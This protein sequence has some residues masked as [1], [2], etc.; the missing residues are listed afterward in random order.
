MY[1]HVQGCRYATTHVTRSHLC[2]KCQQF[3]HGRIE[4]N[5]RE[6]IRQLTNSTKH[7]L[8]PF[9]LYCNV[10][11]CHCR[12]TH[13]TTGHVCQLCQKNHGE[14]EC[15]MNQKIVTCPICRKVSTILHNQQKI[16][17]ADNKCC[18]C[19]DKNVEVYLPKCGHLCLCNDCCDI[20]ANG[21]HAPLDDF[22]EPS[23]AM[24]E[25][26]MGQ[27]RGAIYIII[28]VEMG[29]SYYAKRNDLG[30]PIELF[31]MHNDS[32]GQYGAISSRVSQLNNF[33]RGYTILS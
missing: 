10:E 6:M 16:F 21:P 4:C 31:L 24:I 5:H 32:W 7:D 1:C 27:T 30:Q 22:D 33:I 11:G 18:V 14:N 20:I 19:W 12:S 8:M 15:P 25:N 13:C 29:C 3:G 23:T 28:P 17:G 26:I 2:G 9:E